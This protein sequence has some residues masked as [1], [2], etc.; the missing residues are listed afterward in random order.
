MVSILNNSASDVY[1]VERDLSQIPRQIATTIAAAVGQS[2][3]GPLGPRLN[4]SKEGFSGLYGPSDPAVSF[5]HLCVRDFFED[6]TQ[7]YVN[8]V[9]GTGFAYAGVLLQ[10]FGT[11]G[12]RALRLFPFGLAGYKN[13]ADGINFSSAGG[14]TD[15]NENL[16]F[17]YAIGPG[18]YYN[19]YALDIQSDNIT[20]P[21]NVITTP[22]SSG[23]T[24]ITG[25]YSYRV[26]AIG[27]LGE[28]LAS[29]SVPATIAAS[30]TTGSVTISWNAVAGATGYRIYGRSG[31]HGFIGSVNSGTLSFQDIGSVTPVGVV[32]ATTFAPS[33][34]FTI[35]VYDLNKSANL[36][37]EVHNVSL[38]DATDAFGN[39]LEIAN[40]INNT[41]NYIRVVTNVPSL[42]QTPNSMKTL[43]KSTFIGGLDGSI[44]TAADIVNGWNEFI[45]EDDIPVTVL[46]NA[47]YTSTSV[48]QGIITLAHSRKDCV[49]ILDMPTLQQAVQN[50]VNYRRN[51]LNANSNRGILVTPDYQRLDTE[52]GRLTYTPPSGAVASML[53]LT[54]FVENAGTSPAGPTRGVVRNA[55]QLRYRY[56][57]GQR[58]QLASSQVCY[59]RSKTGVGIYLAEQLTLQTQLSALSFLSVRRIFDVMEGSIKTGLQYALHE[60]NTAFTLSQI[61][62]MLT[63]YLDVL[64]RSG[65]IRA[66]KITIDNTPATRGQGILGIDVAIE[67]TLPINQ[68]SLRTII[69]RQGELVFEETA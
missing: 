4:T 59:L 24:M 33:T 60:N 64:R 27:K 3:R 54:D 63:G 22:S 37:Q 16:A 62:A 69:T 28:T 17:I 56:D 8:R 44:P 53:A 9:V 51:T 41:S 19:N 34:Q 7:C 68:I 40:V 39:Q 23:G 10:D 58:N 15:Q 42:T 45:D 1:V 47:G 29:T 36:P 2:L 26:S 20:F 30:V 14:V 32:P 46:I 66:Y 31:T 65:S 55:Q 12:N 11:F 38:E 43:A 49:Y 52:T 50:A 13:P 18:A 21:A 6:G 57:K 5:L 48:H 67:P 25:A 35:Q 61:T